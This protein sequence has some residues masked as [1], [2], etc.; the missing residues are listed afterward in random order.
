MFIFFITTVQVLRGTITGITQLTA[1]FLAPTVEIVFICGIEIEWSF[2]YSTV[3]H[4]DFLIFPNIAAI[5]VASH[6]CNSIIYINL[7]SSAFIYVNPVG[8]LVQQKNTAIRCLHF[9]IPFIVQVVNIQ[10]NTTAYYP[11]TKVCFL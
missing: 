7:G 2:F 6:F 8:S 4:N 9:N 1:P 5:I 10:I 11:E 3:K